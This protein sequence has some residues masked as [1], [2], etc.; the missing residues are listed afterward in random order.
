MPDLYDLTR[1]LEVPSQGIEARWYFACMAPKRPR[2]TTPQGFRG[3]DFPRPIQPHVPLK[4]LH[5]HLIPTEDPHYRNGSE[6]PIG[7]FM[8]TPIADKGH[9]GR[10]V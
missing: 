5:T 3:P 2:N 6:T 9:A 10:Q 7:S 4:I 1:A 8:L